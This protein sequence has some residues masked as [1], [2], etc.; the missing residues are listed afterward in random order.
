MNEGTADIHAAI[1]AWHDGEGEQ[2][3]LHEFLGLSWEEYS[4]WVEGG[5]LP[6]GF[7]L[8]DGHREMVRARRPEQ[9]RAQ[10]LARAE[11]AQLHRSDYLRLLDKHMKL[12]EGAGDGQQDV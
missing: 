1:A 5:P 9:K 2:V 6:V 12:L 7:G 10:R 11:L 8:R 3:P 4:T